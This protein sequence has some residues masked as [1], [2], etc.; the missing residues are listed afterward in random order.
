MKFQPLDRAFY[1][2]PVLQVARA[3]VGKHLV[4]VT[5]TG[6]LAAGAP[7]TTHKAW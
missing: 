5:P 6:I 4:H 1:S 3:C 7:M 2:R